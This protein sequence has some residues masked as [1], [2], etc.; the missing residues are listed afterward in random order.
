MLKMKHVLPGDCWRFDSSNGDAPDHRPTLT[1]AGQEPKHPDGWDAWKYEEVDTSK[2]YET[3]GERPIELLRHYS[4]HPVPTPLDL[5][6]RDLKPGDCFQYLEAE[7]P[8]ANYV[9]DGRDVSL[10]GLTNTWGLVSTARSA[11]SRMSEPVRR[12]A[13]WSSAAPPPSKILARHEEYV[14]VPG[15]DV[16]RKSVV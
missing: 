1:Y 10:A 5:R 9:V 16:D 6:R 11:E 15:G 14:L 7:G 4:T 8:S 2:Y 13:H 3:H 12:V